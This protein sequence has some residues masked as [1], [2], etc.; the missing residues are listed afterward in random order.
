[1]PRVTVE[2]QRLRL[3]LEPA[4]AAGVADF[5]LRAPS[6]EYAPIW[7]RAPERVAWWNDL[8]SYILAPWCNRIAGGAFVFEGRRV[9]LPRDW[10]D[11]TAIH[12]VVKDRA[13]DIL[14]RSPVSARFGFDSREH[15]GSPSIRAWPWP[16]TCTLRYEL[17]ETSLTHDVA[18]TNLGD[19]PMPCGVG[20]HP[21][22]VR[23]LWDPR[24]DVVVRMNV[25]GRYPCDEMIPRGPARPDEVTAHFASGKPLGMLELDDVFGGSDGKMSV[26]WPASGVR[27]RF[28]C[29]R[30]FGHSVIYSPVD[31]SGPTPRPVPHFCLEPVSMVNDGFNLMARGQAGTG[32]QIVQPGATMKTHFALI[33]E[34]L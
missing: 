9:E 31:R 13:F 27:A 24:D 4:L 7:R 21:Y 8:S 14:D 26:T 11:G 29:S 15:Q 20:F 3:S 23:T 5:S 28:E 12:G 6:G 32:V 17:D 16:F 34:S 19:S 22:F 2:N 25:A 10:K 1:M 30:D 18:I 33:V